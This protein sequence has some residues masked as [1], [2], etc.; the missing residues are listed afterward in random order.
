MAESAKPTAYEIVSTT[1]LAGCPRC[2]SPH[3]IFIAGEVVDNE[4]VYDCYQCHR[5]FTLDNGD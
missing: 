2:Y 1:V 4:I 5:P 3:N